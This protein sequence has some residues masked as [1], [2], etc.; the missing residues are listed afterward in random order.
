LEKVLP[1]AREDIA[2]ITEAFVQARY[3]RQEVDSRQAVLVKATWERIRRA[4]Q[5]KANSDK[6]A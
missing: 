4:L 6:S 2:S 1:V 5:S 3:S